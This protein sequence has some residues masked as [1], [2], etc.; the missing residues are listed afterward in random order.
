MSAPL[1]LAL[2]KA[3]D[4]QKEAE[5]GGALILKIDELLNRKELI[6]RALYRRLRI[7]CIATVATMYCSFVFGAAEKFKITRADNNS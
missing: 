3:D 4:R 1:R 7:S 5:G 2:S 6:R